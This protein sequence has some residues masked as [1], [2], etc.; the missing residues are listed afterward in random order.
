[1]RLPP[2]VTPS[3]RGAIVDAF[4]QPRAAKDALV[5]VHG[6]ALKLKIKAPPVDDRANRAVEN[7]VASLLGVSRARVSVVAGRGSRHKRLAVDGMPPE[8]LATTLDRVL[9]SR[10]HE[11]GSKVDDS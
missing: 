4:V 3:K 2:Y 9:W 8:T 6:P 5:G 7:L 11:R 10:A 1:V